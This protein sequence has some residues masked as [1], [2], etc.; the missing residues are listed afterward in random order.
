[1]SEDNLMTKD[2]SQQTTHFGFKTVEEAEKQQKV[3]NFSQL[4]FIMSLSIFK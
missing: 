4:N 2:N 3:G 1:M